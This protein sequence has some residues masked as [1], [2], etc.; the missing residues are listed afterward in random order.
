MGGNWIELIRERYISFSEKQC[1]DKREKWTEKKKTVKKKKWKKGKKYQTSPTEMWSERQISCVYTVSTRFFFLVATNPCYGPVVG[2][3]VWARHRENVIF[4][5]RTKRS[6]CWP[7]QRLS[8]KKNPHKCAKII[9]LYLLLNRT[10]SRS[11]VPAGIQYENFVRTRVFKTRKILWAL[12]V[13]QP[14]SS[15][16]SSL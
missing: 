2:N 1:A 3:I 5:V 12:I 8:E 9:F 11:C 6:S 4:K 16:Y 7:S 13:F 15:V 14:L 10:L